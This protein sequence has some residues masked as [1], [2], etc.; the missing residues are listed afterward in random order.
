MLILLLIY[1]IFTQNTV[2]NYNYINSAEL[3]VD[4]R[5]F[6]FSYKVSHFRKT[7]HSIARFIRKTDTQ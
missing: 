5:R 3:H 6:Q 4:L 2:V 7:E 1:L